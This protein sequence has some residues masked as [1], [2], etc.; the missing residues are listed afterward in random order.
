MSLFFKTFTSKHNM[1]GI[2]KGLF[3]SIPKP[4]TLINGFMLYQLPKKYEFIEVCTETK[5][6][7]R[8]KSHKKKS[9]ENHQ[10]I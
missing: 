4:V 8:K 6:L 3:C 10:S 7:K 2:T 9:K 5:F 1:K